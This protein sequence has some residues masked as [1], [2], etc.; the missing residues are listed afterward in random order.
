[1]WPK[2]ACGG[3]VSLWVILYIAT[4]LGSEEMGVFWDWGETVLHV[5]N[6]K[7]KVKG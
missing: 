6:Q 5:K 1:M 4:G 7:L 3:W 2:S